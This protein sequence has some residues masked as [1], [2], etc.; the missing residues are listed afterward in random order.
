MLSFLTTSKI[1]RNPILSLEV[2]L[3]MIGGEDSLVD[4]HV[5]VRE[6]HNTS[7]KKGTGRSHQCMVQ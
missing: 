3:D 1:R 5:L 4:G 2:S 7:P 6:S